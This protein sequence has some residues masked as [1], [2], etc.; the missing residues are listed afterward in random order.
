MNPQERNMA[1]LGQIIKLIPKKLIEKLKTRGNFKSL[2][3]SLFKNQISLVQTQGKYPFFEKLWDICAR[4]LK[5]KPLSVRR[6][7]ALV[8]PVGPVRRLLLHTVSVIDQV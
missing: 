3:K 5:Y 6:C 8:G 4:F 2:T 1:V 7:T